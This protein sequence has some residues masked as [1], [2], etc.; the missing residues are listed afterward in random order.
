MRRRSRELNVFGTS[1]LDLFASA[2]AAFIVIAIIVL[3]FFLKYDEV[4][5]E[6]V[7]SL[8][9]RLAEAEHQRDALQA[10]LQ[11]TRS[12]LEAAQAEL[13]NARSQLDAAMREL[14]E[15]RAALEA[16]ER[17]R[18]SIGSQLAQC[19]EDLSSTFLTVLI[20][21]ENQNDV[22]L[23]VIDP[24]GN[25]FYYAQPAFPGVPGELTE[26]VTWGPGVEVFEEADARLGTFQVVYNLYADNAGPVE[27]VGVVYSR[28]GRQ[29]LPR[30]TLNR[31]GVRVPVARLTVEQDGTVTVTTQR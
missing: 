3:P 2:L 15:T 12:Q 17:E 11:D 31:E 14:D 23:H 28:Q 1:A 18:V 30:I 13:Q 16:C 5:M 24:Q 26:D 21:W 10:E 29:E 9:G 20:R 19:I 7:R 27:V 8:Q 6:Q 4:L 22:D 25:E